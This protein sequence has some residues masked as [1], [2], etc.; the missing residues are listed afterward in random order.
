LPSS[1]LTHSLTHSL[2]SPSPQEL[3]DTLS[4]LDSSDPY[5]LQKYYAIVADETAPYSSPITLG[6]L[7]TLHVVIWL[8]G[9]DHPSERERDDE[10]VVREN[11]SGIEVMS[12]DYT[13]CLTNHG[14]GINSR[15]HPDFASKM[16]SLKMGSHSRC[17]DQVHEFLG[18]SANRLV[19]FGPGIS[20]LFTSG[21][22]RTEFEK[23]DSVEF[24]ERMVVGVVYVFTR[25]GARGGG[26]N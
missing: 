14:I 3:E 17:D 16:G 15:S 13:T 6:D 1:P 2:R 21:G 24:T 9:N 5:L 4:P 23:T 12:S 20:F 18:Q 26:T 22:E 11:E 10:I 8:N 25:E 19:I 7:D